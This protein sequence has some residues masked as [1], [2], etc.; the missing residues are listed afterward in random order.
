[1][2]AITSLFRHPPSE[3]VNFT[4]YAD[5]EPDL[6]LDIGGYFNRTP[7]VEAGRV[8]FSIA[9]HAVVSKGLSAVEILAIGFTVPGH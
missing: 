5:S 9:L 6:F 3:P 1:L 4:S 7:L 8:R 2:K